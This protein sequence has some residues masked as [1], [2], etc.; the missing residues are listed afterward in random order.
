M[1]GESLDRQGGGIPEQEWG[2]S[3]WVKRSVAVMSCVLLVVALGFAFTRAT[4]SRIPGQRATLEKLIADRTGLEVRFD[5]VHFAWDLDGAS[6]VFTRVELNDPKAGR[7]RVVAPELRVELDT[8]DF[9]RHSQF[10]FGHVTLRS[11]DI[12]IIR[13]ADAAPGTRPGR[14]AVPGKHRDAGTAG[15]AETALVRR[16]LSWAALMPT[17]RIEVEGARV[18]LRYRD[19]RAARHTFT[20]SQAVVSRGNSSFNAYGTLLLA[21][22][23]GQSLFV[24][25]KLEG[26]A[27]GGRASGD[28][29]FIA[30]RVFLDKLNLPRATGRGTIDARLVLR[31]DRVESGSW[32][33]SLRD[34]ELPGAGARF[35]HVSLNG[36]LTRDAGD[37]LLDFTDLQMARGAR[38][39][40][41]PALSARL[42]ID[43]NSLRVV[44]SSVRAERLPFMAAQLAAGA[45]APHVEHAS[46][47]LPDDW[48]ATAGE[49]R[50]VRFISAQQAWS[51]DAQAGGLEL[52]RASDLSRLS[53]IAARVHMNE[54][55]LTV[56]FDHAAEVM[57]RR[58]AE[59]PRAL[60]LSGQLA[61]LPGTAGWQFDEFAIASGAG[62][63]VAQGR[64]AGEASSTAALAVELHA[65]DHAFLAATWDLLAVGAT[66]PR[67][68]TDIGQGTIT[69]GKL[70]LVAA[71]GGDI[72]WSRSSGELA[73]V[74][75]A[76]A[77]ADLPRLSAGRGA[78][79]FARGG[80]R[81]TLEGGALE[82]LAIRDARV[83]WPR[84]GQPRLRASLEG[85]LSSA[86]LRPML[87]SQGL[88]NLRGNVAIEADARGERALHEPAS[89]RVTARVSGASVPLGDKLPALEGLQGSLRYAGGQLRSLALDGE[90]LG[91]AVQVELRR[92]GARAP[93]FAFKGEAD[94]APLLRLLGHGAAAEQVSGHFAW[95]GTAQQGAQG[96]W[97]V[98]LA[99][100][101]AGLESRLPPPFDKPR[102][103]VVAV[104]ARLAVAADGIRDFELDAGRLLAL[105]GE[106]RG[107]AT[108]ARFEVQGLAGEFRRAGEAGRDSQLDL[109]RLDVERGH[110]ALAAA[111]V[112]LPASGELR[113]DIKDARYGDR[114]L[115]PLRASVAR[116]PGQ[117]SFV[118]ESPAV[119]MH[120][121]SGRGQC[122][123]EGRCRAD[124]SANTTQLAVLLRDVDLPAEWPAAKLHAAGTLEWPVDA[125]REIA[126]SLTGRFDLRTESADGEHQLTA[127][128]TLAEGQVQLSD[129]QG[130]G[131]EPDQVFRGQG[132]IGLVARDYDLTVD[133]ERVALAATAVP[134]PARARLARAWNAVRGSAAR[135]G[136]TDPPDARRVQ[137]HGTWD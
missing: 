115:G 38:L 107:G 125:P 113:I 30:R 73:L 123:G 76:T 8:W 121:L 59:P 63:A 49:L 36:R 89:W 101:L 35:D 25:A 41:A 34:L 114:S 136:W 98:A 91:G 118:F 126:A 14:V 105:Q 16:Y 19:E 56:Q 51:F 109:D 130:T 42:E 119:A 9:V 82:D 134:L 129:V 6:A 64:W 54:R 53:Q 32:Q 37:V 79:Q 103:R 127:R 110:Q 5:N 45:L 26:L 68:L 104:D 80:T 87:E 52:Q 133:Y 132:R 40:R 11:P 72:D 3:H 47:A 39:E 77:G 135:R 2:D 17:G 15:A 46:M 128:A 50:S 58:G 20:L 100:N 122:N 1:T 117:A 27:A 67:G 29:R 74:D 111:T 65:V 78:M 22:D 13:D 31:D 57:L 55:E 106:V 81:L 99:S 86:V 69:E 61:R 66:R 23:V 94:A 124:F 137:W 28:L 4:A 116:A 70:E 75:L 120:Q 71:G 21:Q 24:S 95:S 97:Q 18:H 33:A 102:A 96:A 92:A 83:D 12:E 112:L 62:S 108:Q 43:S 7:I 44:G 90:W 48:A 60:T 85:E 10:S 93:A 84:A 131:P 88:G